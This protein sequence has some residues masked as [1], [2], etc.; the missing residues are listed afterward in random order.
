MCV[1]LKCS[2][3]CCVKVAIRRCLSYIVS[4]CDNSRRSILES[5]VLM[6]NNNGETVVSE[7]HV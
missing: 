1:L 3:A 4:V 6:V 2:L 7:I 5:I